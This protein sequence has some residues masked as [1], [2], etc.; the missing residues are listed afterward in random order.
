[1][2]CKAAVGAIIVSAGAGGALITEG[3]PAARLGSRVFIT[4][5]AAVEGGTPVWVKCGTLA[6][7]VMHGARCRRCGYSVCGKVVG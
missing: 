4:E 7:G 2:A 6:G 5:A 3:G 1:M